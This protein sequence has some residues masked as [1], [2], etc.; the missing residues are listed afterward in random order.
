M[1]NIKEKPLHNLH[2]SIF[3]IISVG[4]YMTPVVQHLSKYSKNK[5]IYI[6]FGFGVICFTLGHFY[7]FLLHFNRV[8]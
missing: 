3:E 2:C 5:K 6:Y 8:I 4:K 7:L 1:T